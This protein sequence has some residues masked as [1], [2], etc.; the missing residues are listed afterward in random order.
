MRKNQEMKEIENLIV[1]SLNSDK[2]SKSVTDEAK[3]LMLQQTQIKKRQSVTEKKRWGLVRVGSFVAALLLV[4]C[5]I[6]LM[7]N[8][9]DRGNGKLERDD[10]Q[11]IELYNKGSNEKIAYLDYEILESTLFYDFVNKEN[12]PIYIREHYLNNGEFVEL[13]VL[14]NDTE[15]EIGFLKNFN[16]LVDVRTTSQV[17]VEYKYVENGSYARFEYN[18]Y[19]YFLH[20]E[21]DTVSMLK[22]IEEL[23][24]Q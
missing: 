16:E 23:T 10:I 2:P 20:C 5:F 14:L 3:Q 15:K 12:V 13:Y 1:E 24:E 17:V 6:P 9:I 8:Q 19:V 21:S 11:S 4:V 7:L 18:G 22:Y